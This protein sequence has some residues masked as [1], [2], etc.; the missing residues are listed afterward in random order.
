MAG[1]PLERVVWTDDD[2]ENMDWHDVAIHA[3]GFEQDGR[4][5][6]LLLDIDYILEWV[7]PA[8]RRRFYSFRI[9]P[10]TLVFED[11]HGIEGEISP[12]YDQSEGNL[13]RIDSVR[14]GE[15]ENEQQ[16]ELGLRPWEI[17]GHNFDLSFLARGYR[18]HMRQQPLHGGQWLDDQERA[19]LSFEQPT[20][21]GELLDRSVEVQRIR[22][23]AEETA[24]WGDDL[25]I[26]A[27]GTELPTPSQWVD[28]L[29]EHGVSVAWRVLGGAATSP[30]DVPEKAYI[31]WYL[32]R[33][34]R[35]R[36][37]DY[38]VFVSFAAE[39]D[40]G[41]TLSVQ[42]WGADEE[43]WLAAFRSALVLLP[44]GTFDSGDYSLPAGEW[45]AVLDC[46][47]RP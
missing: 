14:R 46:R 37:D 26:T 1:G 43:L 31:G 10:A 24:P 36:E 44:T 7:D 6:K 27:A 23:T 30:E 18:Q 35:L 13:L 38:G 42:R 3:I 12:S 34:S 5:A 16:A 33:P 22:E 19:G 8:P 32:Q 28:A 40:D 29:A 41:V 2:F 25:H 4:C 47:E 21:L 45:P 39:D 9:C 11:V 15:P 20:E 17:A